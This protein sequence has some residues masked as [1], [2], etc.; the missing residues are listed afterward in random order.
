MAQDDTLCGYMYQTFYSRHNAF[1]EMKMTL[2]L[3]IIL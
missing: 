1:I 2:H 3:I